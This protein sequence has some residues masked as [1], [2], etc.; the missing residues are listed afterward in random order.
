MPHAGRQLAIVW[1]GGQATNTVI[2]GLDLHARVEGKSIPVTISHDA[3]ANH[4]VEAC[5]RIAEQKIIDA[6]SSGS[7]HGRL[8][9]AD[10][11]LKPRSSRIIKVS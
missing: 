3:F 7:N 10:Q 5:K 11:L 8:W 1:T 2:F 6:R 9:K 4:G